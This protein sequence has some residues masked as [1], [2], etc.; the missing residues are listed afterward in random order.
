MGGKSGTGSHTADLIFW[1]EAEGE[2]ELYES[3]AAALGELMFTGPRDGELEWLPVELDGQDR[4]ELL[5]GL[6]G[7]VVY[8]ADGE[9]LLV[10]AC[11]VRRCGP[12]SL[13]AR[14][15]VLPLNLARHLPREPVKAVTLHQAKM[16][17][18]GNGRWRGEVVLDV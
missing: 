2:A 18:A 7:E 13:S 5:V 12:V 6:L 14:L 8:L 3:A 1:V 17:E 10:A 11:K 4:A 16:D 15:G 9:E